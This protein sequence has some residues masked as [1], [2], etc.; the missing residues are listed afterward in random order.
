[1][2]QARFFK[3]CRYVIGSYFILAGVGQILDSSQTEPMLLYL[4][5]DFRFLLP[6]NP[7]TLVLLSAVLEICLGAFAVL[8]KATLPSIF[9]LTFVLI[10]YTVPI[11]ETVAKGLDVPVCGGF[12]YFDFGLSLK[13]ALVRNLLLQLAIVSI[14]FYLQN[15]DVRYKRYRWI[16]SR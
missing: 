5:T 6:E 10:A 11:G 16:L 15:N 9:I 4:T 8:D 2:N 12:G 1:M 3:I 13:I 7:R 14:L